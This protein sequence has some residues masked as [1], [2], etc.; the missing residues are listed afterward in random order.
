MSGAKLAIVD[1]DFKGKETL[2]RGLV[3]GKFFHSQMEAFHALISSDDRSKAA[4]RNR[5][6]EVLNQYE[7]GLAKSAFFVGGGVKTQL[8]GRQRYSSWRK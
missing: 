5:Y 8:I 2:N 7:Q 1:Q 4:L 6:K 3:F